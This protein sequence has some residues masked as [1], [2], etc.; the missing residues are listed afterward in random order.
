MMVVKLLVYVYRAYTCTIVT[1]QAFS[2]ARASRRH[3]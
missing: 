1:V 2:Y 3:C